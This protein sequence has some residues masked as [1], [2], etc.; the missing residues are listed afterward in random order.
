MMKKLLAMMLTV[1]AL[2]L[3]VSMNAAEARRDVLVGYLNDDF[4]YIYLDAD[5]VRV[6][7]HDRHPYPSID[8]AYLIYATYYATGEK[9]K[10]LPLTYIHAVG[11]KDDMCVVKMFLGTDLGKPGAKAIDTFLTTDTDHIFSIKMFLTAWEAAYGPNY[12]FPTI[13]Q[14]DLDLTMNRSR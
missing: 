3:G 5:T 9:S 4:Q 12:P 7:K 11:M 8:D 13:S 14:S 2:T 1:F 10:G 6:L